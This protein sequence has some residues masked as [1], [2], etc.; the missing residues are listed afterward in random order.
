MTPEIVGH[1]NR[2]PAHV[3]PLSRMAFGRL[4]DPCH[5]CAEFMHLM[6]DEME[7]SG[8]VRAIRLRRL[9]RMLRLMRLVRIF[10]LIPSLHQC[11]GLFQRLEASFWA[12][13]SRPRLPLLGP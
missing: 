3:N 1:L 2:G 9:V 5:G 6:G 8:I 12:S 7:E 13:G 4:I 10:K 11:L